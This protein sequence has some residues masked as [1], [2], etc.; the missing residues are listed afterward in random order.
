M[1]YISLILLALTFLSCD[2]DENNESFNVESQIWVS[3]IDPD[4]NDLLKSL[5]E[6]TIS[7]FRLYYLENDKKVL[8][9]KSNL[10]APYGITLVKPENGEGLYQLRLVLYNPP[11]EGEQTQG[12]TYVRWEDGREDEILAEFSNGQD[13][14]TITKFRY[15]EK[16][17]TMDDVRNFVYTV[18][19]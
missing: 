1:K 8:Y 17:G 16:E 9:Q 2:K 12:T 7:K 3:Y 10:D 11:T 18:D 19:Q 5:G 15:N 4:G 14:R 6:E 13:H